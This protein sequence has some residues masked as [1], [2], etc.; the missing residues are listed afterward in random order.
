MF[1][2]RAMTTR[3]S[4]YPL[5]WCTSGAWWM[6]SWKLIW[7]RLCRN[8][9]SSGQKRKLNLDFTVESLFALKMLLYLHRVRKRSSLHW[10]VLSMR[11]FTCCSVTHYLLHIRQMNW[12]NRQSNPF[13]FQVYFD[14]LPKEIALMEW[15]ISLSDLP[16]LDFSFFV[17]EN[18]MF[19]F[20]DEDLVANL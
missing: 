1:S 12:Q 11:M 16:F 2:R 18:W 10:V 3:T 17:P 4:L 14:N 13:W 9:E 8:L 15:H 5:L 20:F 6:V 7:L 19:K